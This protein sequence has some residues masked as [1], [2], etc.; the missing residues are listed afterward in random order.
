[1]M[2]GMPRLMIKLV[3]RFENPH[4]IIFLC[5]HIISLP[6]VPPRATGQF[7]EARAELTLAETRGAEKA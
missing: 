2:K 3:E 1:M 5:M 4:C 7:A 6:E